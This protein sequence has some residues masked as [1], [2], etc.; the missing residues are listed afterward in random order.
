MQGLQKQWNGALQANQQQLGQMMG[1]ANNYGQGQNNASNQLGQQ[2]QAEGQQT[3][4]NRG[5]YN[6]TV[7]QGLNNSV[8][9]QTQLRNSQINDQTANLQLGVLGQN[10]I[11]YPDLSAYAQLASQPGA[12]SGQ[13]GASAML[14]ALSK[15]SYAPSGK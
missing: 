7:A 6:S 9:G 15:L 11:K 13:N 14:G 3:M 1:I 10:T 2:Q 5:L 8:Q 12:F 4:A